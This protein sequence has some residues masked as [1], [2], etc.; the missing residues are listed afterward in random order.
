MM[1]SPAYH[2]L[3]RHVM[4]TLQQRCKDRA[5]LGLSLSAATGNRLLA[6]VVRDHPDNV[7]ILPLGSLG[8]ILGT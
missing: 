1:I 8:Y 7:T 6:D 3:W 4:R 5:R 2:P